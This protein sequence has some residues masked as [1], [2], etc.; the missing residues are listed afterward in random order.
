MP[1]EAGHDPIRVALAQLGRPRAVARVELARGVALHPPRQLLQLDPEHRAPLGRARAVHRRRL[2]DDHRRLG[3]QEPAL[4]LVDRAR[5]AVEARCEVDQRGPAEPLVPLPARRIREREVDLHLRAPVA[6]AA[7][8]PR[9]ARRRIVEQP[10]VELRGR[11]IRKHGALRRHDV[12]SGEP[13]ADGA[14][15]PDEHLLDVAARLA[16]AAAVTDQLHERLHESRPAAP[17]D[18]HPALL[19]GDA[20]HLRHEAGARRVRPEARVQH[21]RREQPVDPLRLEGLPQPVAARD[22]HVAQ[23]LERAV[24]AEAP[25]PLSG[26]QR[27]VP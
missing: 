19:D 14:P 10:L 20:D 5:D 23:E 25:Q 6:V 9:N 22:E 2:P 8:R 17:G 1:G 26:E 13:D 16:D 21:P 7:R 12:S 15:A 3:R 11:H 18:R 4:G 24:A 27:A